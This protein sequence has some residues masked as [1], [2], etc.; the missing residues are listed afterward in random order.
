MKH[1][2]AG[3]AGLALITLLGASCSQPAS[4]SPQ[5]G[6]QP[7]AAASSS[8]ASPTTGASTPADE[9][10]ARPTLEE[11]RQRQAKF[12]SDR[13][14]ARIG[15]PV[16]EFSGGAP[17]WFVEAVEA[18][19]GMGAPAALADDQQL[20]VAYDKA[21][22]RIAA[23]MPGVESRDLTPDRVGFMR[24][25]QGWFTVWVRVTPR[26][27]AAAPSSPPSPAT[28]P[29]APATDPDA[30]A[31]SP[32]PTP[33]PTPVPAVAASGKPSWWHDEPRQENGRVII[34]VTGEAAEVR[35][36]LRG[37]VRAGRERLESLTGGPV[38]DVITMKATTTM[39]DDTIARAFVQ[40]SCPGS[41]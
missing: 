15:R 27:V 29:A 39:I 21:M 13:L 19:Q 17:A 5:G 35:D 3:L 34:C 10:P 1:F 14:A 26:P 25:P 20:E 30:V 24:A 11:A 8:G 32:A 33:A 22:R 40:M 4:S 28:P 38:R 18:Q 9:P 31:P 41:L 6:G 12:E 37:T 2:S 7:A 16:E 36:A 23:G